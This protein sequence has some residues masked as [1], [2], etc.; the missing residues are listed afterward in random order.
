MKKFKQKNKFYILVVFILV[1]LALIGMLIFQKEKLTTYNSSWVT[2]TNNDYHFSIKTPSYF[3]YYVLNNVSTF[4]DILF[5]DGGIN[6]KDN[7]VS[8]SSNPLLVLIKNNAK[9]IKLNINKASFLDRQDFNIKNF[10]SQ[11]LGGSHDE[12]EQNL[13]K[14]ESFTSDDGKT[15]MYFYLTE[16]L[17]KEKITRNGV[18]WISNGILYTLDSEI[19]DSLFIKDIAKTFK[20][21]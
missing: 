9:Y 17:T 16:I 19:K 8:S 2:Y 13:I 3:E 21:N 6:G 20:V 14:W 7:I 4:T 5:Y 15:I 11:P 12:I 1:T 18:V 10:I